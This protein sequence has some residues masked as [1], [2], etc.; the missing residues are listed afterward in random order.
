MVTFWFWMV[1]GIIMK[2]LLREIFEYMQL[3]MSIV[4]EGSY[5]IPI[6]GKC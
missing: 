6:E 3:M 5:S 2:V 4:P 1:V